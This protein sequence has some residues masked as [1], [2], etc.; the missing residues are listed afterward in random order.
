MTFPAIKIRD[1]G[2]DANTYYEG[3]VFLGD[4]LLV[5]GTDKW[6]ISKEGAN[7]QCVVWGGAQDPW[8]IPP[9]PPPVAKFIEEAFGR[10]FLAGIP[11]ER[12]LVRYSEAVDVGGEQNDF[13]VTNTLVIYPQQGGEITGLKVWQTNLYI[14]LLDNVVVIPYAENPRDY[15]IMNLKVG[16]GCIAPYTLRA[17]GRHGIFFLSASGV[18]A[19]PRGDGI[20]EKVSGLI[21]ERLSKMHPDRL[22]S[23]FGWFDGNSDEY[24]LLLSSGTTLIDGKMVHD[25]EWIYQF[26]FARWLKRTD[27]SPTSIGCCAYFGSQGLR[28]VV[29]DYRGYICSRWKRYYAHTWDTGTITN[30]I[31]NNTLV[32]SNKVFTDEVLNLPLLIIDNVTQKTSYYRIASRGTN[33][34][35]IDGFFDSWI[36]IGDTYRIGALRMIIETGWL[37]FGDQLTYT[38]LQDLWLLLEKKEYIWYRFDIFTNGDAVTPLVTRFGELLNR[39][40]LVGLDVRG[41]TIKFKLTFYGAGET[42]IRGMTVMERSSGRL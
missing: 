10:I 36:S 9:N 32:D 21:D 5:N 12:H 37:T 3:L 16:Y 11:D 15:A 19:Y 26:R 28:S 2:A 24:H 30:I 13:P 34:L 39:E 42:R 41:A 17:C 20:P 14:Y 31:G 8:G 23:A 6:H 35:T 7:W 4:L 22:R 25:E 40:E 33:T 1:G 29:G 27:I 18:R 38:A